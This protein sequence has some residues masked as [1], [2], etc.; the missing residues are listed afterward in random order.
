[1]TRKMSRTKNE[2]IVKVYFS[3]SAAQG[4]GSPPYFKEGLG[5]VLLTTTFLINY[6]PA[7]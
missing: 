2:P 1:M 6:G 4:Y 7:G 3:V 5:V